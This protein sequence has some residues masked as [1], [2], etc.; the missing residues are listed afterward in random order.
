VPLGLAKY[1]SSPSLTRL[2]QGREIATLQSARCKLPALYFRLQSA[3]C[4]RVIRPPKKFRAEHLLKNHTNKTYTIQTDLCPP[5][6]IKYSQFSPWRTLVRFKVCWK[7]SRLGKCHQKG[8]KS[9]SKKKLEKIRQKRGYLL[10]KKL[11]LLPSKK[12][13]DRW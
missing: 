5:K 7:K 1:K 4:L 3:K 13:L 6:F 9:Y 12:H 11:N 10:K 2:V 8:A